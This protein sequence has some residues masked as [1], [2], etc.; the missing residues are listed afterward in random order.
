MMCHDSTLTQHNLL[1]TLNFLFGKFKDE[2]DKSRRKEYMHSLIQAIKAF[3]DSP[4]LVHHHSILVQFVRENWS[5]I[6]QILGEPKRIK[7]DEDSDVEKIV[8]ILKIIMRTL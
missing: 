8:R 4:M 3:K 1:P 7:D 5:I 6:K 2:S